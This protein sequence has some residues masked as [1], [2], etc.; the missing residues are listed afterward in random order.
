MTRTC[1]LCEATSAGSAV[2]FSNQ[3]SKICTWCQAELKKTGRGFCPRCKKAYPLAEMRD[4]Y[5]GE[6]KR[7]INHA[8]REAHKE[9]EAA[10]VKAWKEAN[11]R[12]RPSRWKLYRDPEQ[13]RA[14]ARAWHHANR[15]RALERSRAYTQAK[16][17]ANPSY[18][19]ERYQREK[20]RV[21]RR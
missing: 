15:D 16:A 20:M 13:D 2:R 3:H 5:C 1:A 9:K 21:W 8:Y 19:K 14:R 10:R 11:P 4:G 17:D 6:H 18:W 12:P 7:E